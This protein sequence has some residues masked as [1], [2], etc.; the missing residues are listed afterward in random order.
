MSLLRYISITFW[1]LCTL[2]VTGTDT[3][4][5]TSTDF[6]EKEIREFGYI[7]QDPSPDLNFETIRKLPDEKFISMQKTGIAFSP[8]NHVYW[9]KFILKNESTETQTLI[10][11]A[12][13]SRLNKLQLFL[14]EDSQLISDYKMLGDDFPFYE[15]EISYHTF[16]FKIDIPSGKTYTCYTFNDKYSEGIFL[17]Y[18]LYSKS[19]FESKSKKERVVMTVFFG[20][21]FFVF[22][23]SLLLTVFFRN[24]LMLY[25]A[26]YVLA[27]F[28]IRFANIGYGFEYI[29]SDYPNFNS[30][31]S[32]FFLIFAFVCMFAQVRL[33]LKTKT[34]FPKIDFCLKIIQISFLIFIPY[35]FIYKNLPPAITSAF[36]RFGY[37]LQIFSVTTIVAAILIAYQKTKKKNYLFFLSGFLFGLLTLILNILVRLK[38]VEL[39]FYTD[40]F[41]T[42]SFLLDI[43]FLLLII[44]NESKNTFF[45]NQN[46]KETLTKTKLDAATSLIKGQQA[47]RKILSEKLDSDLNSRLKTSHKQIVN[48]DYS[49]EKNRKELLSL[50]KEMEDLSSDLT[51]FSKEISMLDFQKTTIEKAISNLIVKLNNLNPNILFQFENLVDGKIKLDNFKSHALFQTTQELINNSLKYAEASQIKVKLT[52]TENAII[53]T[54]RDNGK[55]FDPNQKSEGIGLKNIR[56]RGIFFDGEFKI[57]SDSSGSEF[58]FLIPFLD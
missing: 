23:L 21:L 42:F 4:R 18:F 3:L 24:K 39:N 14:E 13:N 43:L 25:F 1:L 15:R 22:I 35:I 47:E 41:I 33:Y 10:L 52:K 36:L 2:T 38:V 20:I 32:Y 27:A 28:M 29:W 34:E 55:G 57:K 56:S 7:F 50:G 51:R 31:S 46:L 53:L 6:Q 5:I 19:G 26:L 11:E 54:V 44:L 58:Y 8:S 40:A 16:L 48:L 9:I 49:N 37:F 45:E 17:P 30:S 12:D